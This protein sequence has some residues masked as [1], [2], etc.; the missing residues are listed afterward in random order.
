MST[1][2][3]GVVYLAFAACAAAGNISGTVYDPSGAVVPNARVTLIPADGSP[4][5][6]A[7][8]AK[9]DYSFA[10]VPPGR[11][12]VEVASPGFALS[13]QAAVVTDANAS[14]LLDI[15]LK[16]GAIQESI[17]VERRGGGGAVGAVPRRV[18]VGGNVQPPRI[19]VGARP[20]YPATQASGRVLVQMVVLRDGSVGSPVVIS[21][22]DEQLAQ[23]ALDAVRQMRYQPTMLNG[24]TVETVALITIVFETR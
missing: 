4:Q 8:D 6:S 19:L 18:R 16:L 22:P 24:E 21:A 11:Y 7:T 2:R 1:L 9:G 23:S 3:T 12:R 17:T 20:A 13:T 14:A 10:V 15:I 5:G